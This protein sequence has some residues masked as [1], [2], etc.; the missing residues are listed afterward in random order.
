MVKNHFPV[1]SSF[2]SGNRASLWQKKGWYRRATLFPGIGVGSRPEGSESW[3]RFS[4]LLCHKQGT[5]MQPLSWD[6]LAN[7]K[8]AGDT[9]PEDQCIAALC[10][11][12]KF[13]EKNYRKLP[14]SVRR[15]WSSH[16]L[17]LFGWKKKKSWVIVGKVLS[18]EGINPSSSK[19]NI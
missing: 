18:S 2:E 4:A 14:K 16:Q 17:I 7:S 19:A 11:S 10:K 8:S 5:A 12:P 1:W 15:I 9:P 3:C 6:Q 13:G